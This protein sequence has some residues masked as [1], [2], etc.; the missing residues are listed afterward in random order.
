MTRLPLTER[1]IIKVMQR[2]GSGR[3]GIFYPITLQITLD[4]S[5]IEIRA[6]LENLA[7][8]GVIERYTSK[9]P[10]V[11]TVFGYGYCLPKD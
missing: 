5:R 10:L 7:T 8:Q 2:A 9:I 11:P 3:G 6:L 1:N 4:G